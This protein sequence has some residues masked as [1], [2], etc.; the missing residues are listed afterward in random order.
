MAANPSKT[1]L[2]NR[3]LL[4]LRGLTTSGTQIFLTDIDDTVFAAPMT[5]VDPN[6]EDKRL[7]CTLYPHCLKKALIDIQPKF[8]RRYADLGLEIKVTEDHVN[9]VADA[10][11][12]YLFDLPSNYLELIAQI[13]EALKTTKYEA[14][15]RILHSYAHVVKGTDGQA[16]YCKSN[17]IAAAATNKPITGTNYTD[18]WTLFNTDDDYGAD[19]E[20]GKTYKS[21]QSGPVLLTNSYSNSDGDSAYIEYLA[22]V[23]AGVS[24]VPTYYDQGFI[25]AFTTLLASEMA[26]YSTEDTRRQTLRNEYERLTKPQALGLQAR[27]EFEE[28]VT[29]WLDARDD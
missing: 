17:H 13:D 10:D 26:P 20:T 22:Y 3:A 4:K 15:V 21:A 7:I 11:W 16:W 1:N 18:Y 8:A 14:Q 25:E 23:L 28:E 12:Y 27:P 5:A 29:S 9:L 24:D 19:W 2:C 6:K